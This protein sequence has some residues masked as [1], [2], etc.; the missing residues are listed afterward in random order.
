MR[1]VESDGGTSLDDSHAYDDDSRYNSSPYSD[2]LSE[3]DSMRSDALSTDGSLTPSDSDGEDEEVLTQYIGVSSAR[4]ELKISQVVD[5]VKTQ[6]FK[7]AM[8]ASMERMPAKSGLSRVWKATEEA[9]L[10]EAIEEAADP[11]HP[12]RFFAT[13]ADQLDRDEVDVRNKLMATER[14]V[15]MCCVRAYFGMEQLVTLG[16]RG[17]EIQVHDDNN[18]LLASYLLANEVGRPKGQKGQLH[19]ALRVDVQQVVDHVNHVSAHHE[20]RADWELIVT[21][22]N[23]LRE[24][25]EV[26]PV[27]RPEDPVRRTQLPST[28]LSLS[29]TYNLTHERHRALCV[30]V[31]ACVCMCVRVRVRVC[32]FCVP[33]SLPL[34]LAACLCV[35][36]C[37]C[38][39]RVQSDHENENVAVDVI[40]KGELLYSSEEQACKDQENSCVHHNIPGLGL[41]RVKV[42]RYYRVSPVEGIPPRRVPRG[43]FI[44]PAELEAESTLFAPIIAAASP[45]PKFDCLFMHALS[46]RA[47]S[48]MLPAFIRS[49]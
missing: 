2:D 37:L 10:V 31:R 19:R 40:E 5:K 17:P 12:E 45:S 4:R 28:I 6:V 9:E 11:D 20:D 7:K 49:A 18:H 36:L 3:V 48:V 46:F 44:P 38:L 43:R 15:A 30:C 34:C 26:L 24:Y 21:G 35:W 42:I 25:P 41:V 32:F 1:A 47:E 33:V 29:I 39:F 14:H 22:W 27:P 23:V 8:D 16:T 13:L